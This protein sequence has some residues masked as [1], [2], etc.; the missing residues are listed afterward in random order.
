LR[1]AANQRRVPIFLV[2]SLSAGAVKPETLRLLE[3][4]ETFLPMGDF[5]FDRDPRS[6]EQFGFV[7]G[8]YR[9]EG[10]KKGARVGRVEVVLT[11]LT[12]FDAKGRAKGHIY[13]QAFLP[14]GSLVIEGNSVIREGPGKFVLPIV[15]G[16]GKYAGAGGEVV[17][18]DIGGGDK[19][20]NIFRI[21]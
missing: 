6:G 16:S 19:S 20:A 8:L 14:G 2:P 11:F 15:G 12:D 13:A 7:D 1:G 4:S 10:T 9:W 18:R 3:I 21:E 17:I 5:T